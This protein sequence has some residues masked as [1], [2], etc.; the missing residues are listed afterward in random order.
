[1][2]EIKNLKLTFIGD[3]GFEVI[4]DMNLTVGAG[5]IVG[6]VGE[7]GSGKTTAA[8]AVAGLLDRRK[9][10]AEG[11]ILLGGTDLMT[12]SE[13]AYRKIRGQDVTMVF[14]EPLSS[15]D[16]LMRVGRQVEEALR[17]HTDM[18]KAARRQAAIDALRSV[19]LPEPERIYE[20]YPHELSGGMCQRVMLAAAIVTRPR[21]LI[22]D[23]PTT[24]LDVSVQAQILALIRRL[25]QEYRMAVLFISHDLGV[26]RML[27]DRVAVMREGRIVEQGK[28]RDIFEHPAEA[29]TRTLVAEV[30]KRADFS[31]ADGDLVLRLE[32]VNAYYR[33]GRG[34]RQ[35]LYDVSFTVSRGEI[36]GLVG[37]SG[38]GKSTTAKVVTGI[39]ESAT[40]TV[41]RFGARPQMVFQDPL[42][43]LNPSKNVAWLLE[44]P[45]RVADVPKEERRDRVR[46]ILAR[47]GLSEEHLRRRPAELSGGQRQRVAIAAALIQ[48]PALIVADEPV[49]ALD[50]TIQSQILEL[51]L[52][53]K[54]ELGLSYLFISHDLGVIYRICDRV[55]VMREGRIVE[56]G[57]VSE[58]YHHPK[59]PY[60]RHLA[61]L[62]G[63][64]K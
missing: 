45:L 49:S 55:L 7:S 9:V 23:E 8:L 36:V 15:L 17:L 12:C 59:D 46:G 43:S 50:V 57:P 11:S 42:S 16:P 58:I 61:S 22:A 30:R 54:R 31:P 20:K 35:A 6:I 5:E 24:A 37:E 4:H 3:A 27:C 26:I 10:R 13:E 41:E 60:T 44:E 1:M 2:L 53:L 39:L 32:N 52:E 48:R 40:G 47:V 51:M 64:I 62:A 18:D 29:Y 63:E 28:T 21:L 25:S 38:C 56:Q 34:R 33:A 19:E 14:Q